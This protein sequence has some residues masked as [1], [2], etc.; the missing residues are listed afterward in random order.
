MPMQANTPGAIWTRQ[1]PYSAQTRKTLR[2]RAQYF[3]Q[4]LA[5][6]KLKEKGEITLNNLQ[7]GGIS[8]ADGPA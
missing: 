1:R 3:F 6:K 2:R 4:L 8:R 5:I 7:P